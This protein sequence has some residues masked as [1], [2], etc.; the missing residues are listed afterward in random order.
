MRCPRCDY[1]NPAGNR[2]CGMCGISLAQP[3]PACGFVNPPDHRFCGQCGARLIPAF[4]AA[5]ATPAPA[6]PVVASPPAPSAALPLSAMPLSTP[7]L[8]APP[9]QA[10]AHLN[11]EHRV[12]TVI[13]ADVHGSTNLLERTG[14]EKW[15]ALMNEMFQV[16]E[17]E[18][19]RFG[20]QV[21]Q[22]RGD[23]LVAFFGATTAHEDDP[24]RAVLAGLAMQEAVRRYAGT[25]SGREGGDL[26]LRVGINTG[27]VIVTSVGDREYHSED[28]AMGEAITV[29]ARMESSAE[30]GTVLVSAHTFALTQD[31]F[32]W[33]ALGQI[34]VKGISTPIAV[35]RPLRHRAETEEA[36]ARLQSC[37][38]CATLIGREAE[39]R[40]LTESL[41]AVRD[42][43]GG[44]VLLMGDRGMG[45]S[46]LLARARQNVARQEALFA[47]AQ[48]E[49][50]H[51]RQPVMWLRGQ[52][53]SF[54][55]ERP[56]S[57]WSDLL[58]RWLELGSDDTPEII[59]A[60]LQRELEALL[61]VQA[62]DAF[63]YLATLFDLPVDSAIAERVRQMD[64]VRLQQELFRIVY[65]CMEALARRGPL[66]CM[67]NHIHWADASSLAL[68]KYCLPLC[69]S[70]PI[71]WILIFRPDRSS[72]VWAF[73]H[74]V[75]TEF[76]HRLTTLQ[77]GPLNRRESATF[78]ERL[79]GVDVLPEPLAV[80][81]LDRA[82]G[83]PYF[84]E[85]LARSL[86]STGVLARNSED[87]AWRLVRPADSVVLPDSLQGLLQSRIDAL[88]PATRRVLQM[89]SAVGRVFWSE[90]LQ[91]LVSAA[92][93]EGP[94][95]GP[96]LEHLTALQRAQFINEQGRVPELGT[97]YDFR[98]ALL[99]EV[100]YDGLLTSQRAAYHLQIAEYF[101]TRLSAEVRSQYYS[102]LAHHYQ[103][104][105]RPDREIDYVLKAARQARQVYANT[106]ALTAYAR[107]LALF[108]EL[109]AAA[110]TA[111][112][113]DALRVRRFDVYSAR[114]GIFR[115]L[116]Q[117]G[118]FFEE[119]ETMLALAQQL[120]DHPEL[121]VDALLLQPNVG[122]WETEEQLRE[123][124][125]LIE[126]ALQLARDLG[127]RKR[128][129]VALAT[130][131]GH[132]YNLGNSAW[133][134]LGEASI[135]LARE[136][137]DRR[138]EVSLLTAVGEIFALSDPQRSLEYLELA[139]PICQELGDKMA[140]LDLLQLV[141]NQ[142]ENSGDYYRRLKE[143]HEP[144]LQLSREIGFRNGESYALMFVGQ[145]RGIYLGDFDG[146]R[147]ALELS[148]DMSADAPDSAIFR[149]L[150]LA[151][152][153]I[154]EGQLE[155]ARVRL[156][157]EYGLERLL[158]S[159]P[160]QSVSKE[161]SHDLLTFAQ[162]GLSLV[163]MQWCNAMADATHA[164]A[165][166]QLAQ[167]VRETL[168]EDTH[169][170]QQYLMVADL[171][172]AAARLRLAALATEAAEREQHAAAALAASQAALDTY[173]RFGFV[174]PV[175]ATDEE[176]LYIH[177]LALKANGMTTPAAEYLRRAHEEMLRKANLIPEDSP[178]RRSY[179]EALPL[180]RE[181]RAA[182]ALSAGQRILEG[183]CLR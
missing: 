117:T 9:L 52:G 162:L 158:E 163:W 8:Q 98:S 92:W 4:H 175:E 78:I 35:Y 55:C 17:T 155:A 26:Q 116:G 165:T 37:D 58:R 150:R 22:F 103:H 170:S 49:A 46:F 41:A 66:V 152:L 137:G 32:E 51:P 145:L 136:L 96:L 56:Y 109:E 6:A 72:P 104:A 144:Q 106:E 120:P 183:A 123:G 39:F 153:D 81:L 181:I 113:K 97:A 119:A 19:Y 12:A 141:G 45:K 48:G 134:E 70:A 7:P 53:R 94:P 74:F 63:A 27:E 11:G 91:T 105:G 167:R 132:Y 2:F 61:N 29:A 79:V 13:L 76:P 23:G 140:Q 176:L 60:R 112:E 73:R 178:Y 43:R 121:L 18:I 82:E 135:Q 34:L 16:L 148:F 88:A 20:G 139:L 64:A 38:L 177:H 85:E 28:T 125:A 180:H 107:A 138:F 169:F 128:E 24:E 5:G 90:L 164:Q 57:L 129:M 68:L 174:R 30:P 40:A 115:L 21:D 126:R 111:K 146:G 36:R 161:P 87:D 127:E 171:R 62:A 100:V 157:Q 122:N 44:V 15:V 65:A 10:T 160:R 130:L 102:L 75:E 86:I 95:P 80:A 89:A 143:C 131:A 142:M 154:E 149:T 71:L 14:T 93:G 59:S 124:T 31:V 33:E 69:D 99:Y 108:T 110:P 166:L 83:N 67:L 50:D 179:L 133:L 1:D 3:C 101:E 173:Q 182:Y 168:V 84:I 156:T 147:L 54:D 172:V 47:E 159:E 118:R 77:L 25:L 114:A 151:Q 42:Q